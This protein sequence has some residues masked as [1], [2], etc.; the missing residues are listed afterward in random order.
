MK[1]KYT[2]KLPDECI[3]SSIYIIRGQKVMLDVDLAKLYGVQTKILNQ[4]MKR[5]SERFPEDFMFQ[6]KEKDLVFLRSQF[7]T[8]SLNSNKESQEK[9]GEDAIYLM[10]SPNRVWPCCPVCF[11]VRR[12][13]KST[14]KS[15]ELL[16][17]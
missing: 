14:S 15:C 10:L 1:N 2:Q 9:H 11:G 12:S 6:L 4:A 8:S 5:N 17:K 7:V 3:E 16:P 13:L